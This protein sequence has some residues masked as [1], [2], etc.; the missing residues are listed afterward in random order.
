MP[1]SKSVEGQM[2]KNAAKLWHDSISA[3]VP[4]CLRGAKFTVK[5]SA[6]RALQMK[7]RRRCQSCDGGPS[8][9]TTSTTRTPPPTTITAPIT[10]ASSLA[11]DISNSTSSPVK[12][13]PPKVPQIRKSSVGKQRSRA[14]KK[15]K[16]HHEKAAFKA[17]TTLLHAEQKKSS[18]GMGGRKVVQKI[19]QDF[20]VD[21]SYRTITRYVQEGKIGESPKKNGSPGFIQPWIFQSICIAVSSYIQINQ[22]NGKSGNNERKKLNVVMMDMMGKN[23][24]PRIQLLVCVLNETAIELLSSTATSVEDRRVK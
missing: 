10:S 2:L 9:T 18:G 4:Q 7:L 22:V 11:S 1:R 5:E 14:N 6:D 24:T 16:S 21:L 15:I 12:Y 20:G 3:S 8:I 13:P 19:S 23:A 17:A